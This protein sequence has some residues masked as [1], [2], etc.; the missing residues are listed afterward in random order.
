[1]NCPPEENES[2]DI[3]GTTEVITSGN[4]STDIVTVKVNGKVV[5]EVKTG[6]S[7]SE[8]KQKSK[9]TVDKNGIIIKTE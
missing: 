8:K 3:E 1:L 9:L 6:T 5:Q 2:V 4:D 7:N